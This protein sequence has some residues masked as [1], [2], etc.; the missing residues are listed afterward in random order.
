M[1]IMKR[2]PNPKTATI[3]DLSKELAQ[4]RAELEWIRQVL[5]ANRFEG[6]WLSPPDAAALIGVSADRILSE[7]KAAERLRQARK[8]SDLIYGEHYFNAMNPHVVTPKRQPGRCIS[9]SF[10]R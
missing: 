6:P 7:I 1:S 8:K 3:A 5:A 4:V 2:K 9:S 10:P